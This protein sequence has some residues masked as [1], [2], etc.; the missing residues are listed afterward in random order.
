MAKLLFLGRLEQAAGCTELSISLYGRVG[1]GQL[2]ALLSDA[3]A[4][5]LRS[6]QIK[7]AVNGQLV[8]DVNA[9]EIADSDELAFL[10]PVSGG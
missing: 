4:E 8:S 10:P 6:P 7:L 2:L 9:L 3:L 5:Q 1:L